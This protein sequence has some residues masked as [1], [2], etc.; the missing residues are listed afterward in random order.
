MK[1]VFP[2][3]PDMYCEFCRSKAR[4]KYRKMKKNLAGVTVPTGFFVYSCAD[5]TIEAMRM[6]G[7]G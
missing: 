7:K 3:E 5:C 1:M 2:A 6:A 4:A